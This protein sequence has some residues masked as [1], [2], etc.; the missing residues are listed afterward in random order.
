MEE[1]LAFVIPGKQIFILEIGTVFTDRINS[2]YSVQNSIEVKKMTPSA[3]ALLLYL[4]SNEDVRKSMKDIAAQLE[5][6]QM[7]VSRGF[8]E[9]IN[10]KLVELDSAYVPNFHRLSASKKEIW[11]MGHA[12][13][14]NPVRKTIYV[15]ES[16]LP[17]QIRKLLVLS[18]ESA[19]SEYSMLSKPKH[20][21]VGLYNKNY[22]KLFKDIIIIPI[23]EF[24][25]LEIQIFNHKMTSLNG[26][27]NELSTALTLI[28]E[29]DERVK[30]E[31]DDT[32]Y[33]YFMRRS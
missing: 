26:V 31:I 25:T 4:L 5:M 7:S 27:L 15:N 14:S 32:L 21:V 8:C 6:S 9:L 17:E 11:K 19:L 3:Q 29:V 1:R 30:G 10:L 12:F 20:K 33:D 28:D 16:S 2:K 22:A 23:I 18:G 13:M 24:D